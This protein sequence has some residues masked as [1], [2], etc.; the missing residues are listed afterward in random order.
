MS[1]KDQYLE[2]KQPSQARENF[3][4]NSVVSSIPKA[5]IVNNMKP[6]TVPGPNGTKLTF[7]VMPDF[8]TLDGLRVS[9]S[10]ATA[11]K[12]AN[13]Y[14]LSLPNTEIAK[15]IY[16][17]ADI[18][19]N[20]KPL[21][22]TGT[23]VDGKF[24]NN[25][26][27]LDKGV[28]YSAFNANYND[29]VNKQLANQGVNVGDNSKIVDGFAKNIVSPPADPSKL[30]I[31]GLWSDK[32]KGPI[33][34]GSG[35]S[36]HSSDIHSEYCTYARLIGDQ[37]LVTN[38]DGSQ[39]TKPISEVY[40]IKQYKIPNSIK[41]ND[42]SIEPTPITSKSEQTLTQPTTPTEPSADK[43][44]EDK[45]SPRMSF[46]QKIDNFLSGLVN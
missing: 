41:Q 14:G 43:T 11:Q 29:V 17:A 3:V 28:G 33:Q 25:Q 6:I 1:F 4:Y 32:N 2:F 31:Y 24:Y 8:L 9:L 46:L 35:E 23:T 13:H 5:Q 16:N 10:G 39:V 45:P 19:V 15:Q 42:K 27:V 26:A 20:A 36:P 34:G 12:I 44:N 21:S 18:K 38:P 22:G 30:G 37:V 7:K 40:N